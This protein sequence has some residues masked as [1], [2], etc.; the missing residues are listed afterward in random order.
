MTVN[1]VVDRV[2]TP[3]R[4]TNTANIP[5]VV[6]DRYASSGVYKVTNN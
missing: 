1:P 5:I 3:V 4:M 2:A 6:I